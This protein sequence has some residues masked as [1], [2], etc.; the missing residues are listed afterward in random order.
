MKFSPHFDQLEFEKDAP[1]PVE[2]LSIFTY[3]CVEVLEPIRAFAG[4]PMQ[5]TSGY[6]NPAAN[7]AAHGQP[8]SEHMATAD[9]CACDFFAVWKPAKDIFDWCRMSKTLPFHQL[10]LEHSESGISIIHVSVNREKVGVRSVLEGSTH[11]ASAYT[12]CTYAPYD[13]QGPEENA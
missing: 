9:W 10:I 11:N 13:P 2:C 8:N 3:L 7:A 6:R 12:P 4:V 1:I 5:M